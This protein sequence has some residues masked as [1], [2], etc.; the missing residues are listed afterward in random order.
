LDGLI[1]RAGI[2]DLERLRTVARACFPDSWGETALA[3]AL[4]CRGAR[5]WLALRDETS[6]SAVIGFVLARRIVD[7]LEIDLVGVDPDSRR[8]GVA[9]RLLAQ[10]L[11]VER[12]EGLA[13]ARLELSTTNS[14]AAGLYASQGF[15]VVGRRPRYYPDGS[16]ALLLSRSFA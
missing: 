7:L 13:E 11:D 6:G 8:G 2:D 16:D 15:V 4:L 9:A 1:R 12:G 14:A 5:A 3:G 10:L